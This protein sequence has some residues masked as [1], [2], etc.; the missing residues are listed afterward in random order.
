MALPYI[1]KAS[2]Y[3]YFDSWRSRPQRLQKIIDYG[4]RIGD[5]NVHTQELRIQSPVTT[6]VA[7]LVLTGADAAT[8]TTAIDSNIAR[9]NSFLGSRCTWAD[10]NGIIISNYIPL[11]FNYTATRVD[12]YTD[13]NAVKYKINYVING[14]VDNGGV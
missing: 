2:E 3:C 7:V 5:T 12:G 10:E 11:N 8:V 9:L 4:T 14:I 13:N 6:S 1:K